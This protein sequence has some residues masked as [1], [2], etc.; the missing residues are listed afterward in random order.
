[1]CPPPVYIT[2]QIATHTDLY[3]DICKLLYHIYI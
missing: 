3:L 2:I 1:M